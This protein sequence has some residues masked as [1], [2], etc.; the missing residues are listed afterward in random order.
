MDTGDLT[1]QFGG[2]SIQSPRMLGDHPKDRNNF[3]ILP[4]LQE[5][6]W[7]TS[8]WTPPCWNNEVL[9]IFI[10]NNCPDAAE[11]IGSFRIRLNDIRKIPSYC[12]RYK[13]QI[14]ARAVEALNRHI[15]DNHCAVAVIETLTVGRLQHFVRTCKPIDRRRSSH[16]RETRTPEFLSLP[17]FDPASSARRRRRIRRRQRLSTRCELHIICLTHPRDVS[18]WR[19]SYW[20]LPKRTHQGEFRPQ[21]Q[22][23]LQW[24]LPR[25]RS[26]VQSDPEHGPQLIRTSPR[27]Y[28]ESRKTPRLGEK[29][30]APA[31][32][33]PFNQDRQPLAAVSRSAWPSDEWLNVKQVARSAKV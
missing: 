26:A 15:R 19:R 2:T 18:K 23:Q 7:E 16:V 20:N 24:R 12:S 33:Q 22:P 27:I 10:N 8:T 29:D 14:K 32:F 25:E 13:A 6:T 30:L 1:Q 11:R 5:T 28:P 31:G 4:P 21:L 9:F 3:P 17:R